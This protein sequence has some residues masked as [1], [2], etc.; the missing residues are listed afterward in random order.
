MKRSRLRVGLPVGEGVP[1]ESAAIAV[2]ISSAAAACTGTVGADAA[3]VAA[4]IDDLIPAKSVAA[5]AMISGV[6]NTYDMAS[7]ARL[8]EPN[9]DAPGT[10]WFLRL[11]RN[12]RI[13]SAA[14]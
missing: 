3:T 6:A 13:S 12:C 11:G 10:C 1:L 2:D 14:S 7:S 5:V 8:C 4:S 9:A